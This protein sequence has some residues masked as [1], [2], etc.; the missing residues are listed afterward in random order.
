MDQTEN[1][2]EDRDV[3]PPN[4]VNREDGGKSSS[5]GGQSTETSGDREPVKPK[6]RH[7]Q[8]MNHNRIKPGLEAMKTA[9]EIAIAA[10]KQRLAGLVA[11]ANSFKK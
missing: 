10:E 1:G 9:L 5:N 7:D 3:V 6:W 11:K 4:P 2:Q 8:E